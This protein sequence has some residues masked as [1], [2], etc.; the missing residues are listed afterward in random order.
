[1]ELETFSNK[2][3][4]SASKHLENAVKMFLIHFHPPPLSHPS[5][6]LARFTGSIVLENWMKDASLNHKRK[7]KSF[8]VGRNIYRENNFTTS[9]AIDSTFIVVA[10]AA[11]V[12]AD[13]NAI[14]SFLPFNF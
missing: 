12:D 7:K 3:L 1:M 10:T 2:N 13:A 9:H 11:V 5:S 4:L 14:A 6:C 8:H